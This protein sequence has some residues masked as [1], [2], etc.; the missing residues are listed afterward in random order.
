M[1]TIFC[2]FFSPFI[3]V[4]SLVGGKAVNYKFY[5]L[6]L[7]LAL[8]Y[9]LLYFSLGLSSPD[10]S[11]IWKVL[12]S[13]ASNSV[14]LTDFKILRWF[15][16]TFFV[17]LL[18]LP[19]ETYVWF[20][21]FCTIYCL[22]KVS[23]RLIDFGYLK[24]FM[25]VLILP[26]SFSASFES[27]A[28]LLI[29]IF[30]LVNPNRANFL[31]ASFA[32]A[33]HFAALPVILIYFFCFRSIGSKFIIIFALIVCLVF[34]SF[35]VFDAKE[36]LFLNYAFMK[37]TNYTSGVWSKF[38]GTTELV[39]GYVNGIKLFVL[40][41]YYHRT[42]MGL[43][44]SHRKFFAA[45]LLF[46]FL[47]SPFRTLSYRYLEFV[48]FLLVLLVCFWTRQ[49]KFKLLVWMM[50]ALTA[51]KINNIQYF[52]GLD[53]GS[54]ARIVFPVPSL[55]ASEMELKEARTDLNKWSPLLD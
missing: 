5:K 1:L 30:A 35:G 18:G 34:F 25:P 52:N 49:P 37:V 29:S 53:S 23:E 47:M 7:Q 8:F 6:P 46:L 50:L 55:L 14:A 22:M 31:L 32:V 54:K 40:W 39:V 17:N 26:L 15:F 4:M 19:E 43:E 51:F 36:N 48:P 41:Y 10:T 38:T 28:A 20:V 12:S 44:N 9:S 11:D 24:F 2:A 33:L 16:S 27:H 45:T 21:H 13:V 3:F 42:K